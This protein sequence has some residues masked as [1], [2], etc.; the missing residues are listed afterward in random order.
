MNIAVD[1][2]LLL[3]AITLCVFIELCW[4]K[5][6]QSNVVL[7]KEEALSA[8][9]AQS[10]KNINTAQ[11]LLFAQDIDHTKTPIQGHRRR[12][13]IVRG[14]AFN[15]DTIASFADA[16]S[17]RNTYSLACRQ[18]NFRTQPFACISILYF[19]YDRPAESSKSFEIC[20]NIS[21]QLTFAR[22]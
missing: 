16:R 9:I 19:Y 10:N 21:S 7:K 3:T 11:E 22:V 13:S 8:T 17:P 14:D 1:S 6:Q 20:F 15:R 12:Y 4:Y 2:W 5:H 18:L